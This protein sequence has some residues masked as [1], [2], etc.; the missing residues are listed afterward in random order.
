[1]ALD[2]LGLAVARTKPGDGPERIAVGMGG[3]RVDRAETARVRRI[4][5]EHDLQLVEPLIVE[6]N[7]AFAAMHLEGQEIVAAI[8]VARRLDRADRAVLELQ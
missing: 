2:D 7:G 6:R 5:R 4:V 8:G 3:A 1:M